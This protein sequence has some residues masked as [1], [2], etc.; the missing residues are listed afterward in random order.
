MSEPCYI[1]G[2]KDTWATG[3]IDDEWILLRRYRPIDGKARSLCHKH[4]HIFRRIDLV[5]NKICKIIFKVVK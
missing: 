2:S 4:Y 3:F 1:C 5:I